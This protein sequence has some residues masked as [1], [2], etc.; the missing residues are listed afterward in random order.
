MSFVFLH[1]IDIAFIIIFI[2]FLLFLVAIML[3]FFTAIQAIVIIVISR[4]YGIFIII[5]L[6]LLVRE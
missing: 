1:H 6:S 4:S 2:T 3:A 5:W